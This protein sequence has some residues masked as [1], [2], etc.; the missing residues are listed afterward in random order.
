MVVEKVVPIDYPELRQISK[1]AP[2]FAKSIEG[3]TS[4]DKLVSLLHKQQ[5]Q[6][7]D[8]LPTKDPFVSAGKQIL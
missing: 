4:E 6:S 8:K 3:V 7:F 2:K 1:A 5:G